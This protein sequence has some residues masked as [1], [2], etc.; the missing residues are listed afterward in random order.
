MYRK[1]PKLFYGDNFAV[2]KVY[3][4]TKQFR[5]TARQKMVYAI[6]HS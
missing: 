1:K 5:L 4:A 3:V 6:S 2:S